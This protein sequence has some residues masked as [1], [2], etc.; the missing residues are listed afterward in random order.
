M[1][2]SIRLNSKSNTIQG[3]MKVQAIMKDYK[4][5]RGSSSV[6]ALDAC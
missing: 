6:M 3:I 5:N 2:Q 1:K 4:K